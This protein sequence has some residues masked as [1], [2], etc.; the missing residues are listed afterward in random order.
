MNQS[1]PT[2]A[3]V[4]IARNCE[5]TIEQSLEAISRALFPWSLSLTVVVES[6]SD[7]LTVSALNK[8]KDGG[9]RFEFVSLGKLRDSRPDRIDRLAHCREV[10]RRKLFELA[11]SVDWVVVADMD[12]PVV[13]IEEG[14]L[15][16]SLCKHGATADAIFA[17][18]HPRYYDVFAL[19][20]EGWVTENYQFL[21]ARLRLSGFS[22]VQAKYEALI[23]AQRR[24]STNQSEIRVRSAFGG[25]SAYRGAAYKDA[26]YLEENSGVCE[27]VG[28]NSQ[29]SNSGRVLIIDPSLV[30]KAPLE[31]VWASSLFFKPFWKLAILWPKLNLFAKL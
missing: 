25:L 22:S 4:A 8:L 30:V 2:I 3:L 16:Q 19:R 18:S 27:H 6:D 10:A 26:Y 9:N 1:S 21:E 31:H 11:P 17:N 29:L 5:N 7:D 15:W 24:I 14:D 12:G 28:L 23:K 13:S 20:A